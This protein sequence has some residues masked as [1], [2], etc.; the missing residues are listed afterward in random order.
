MWAGRGAV[1]L[2]TSIA[3]GAGCGGRSREPATDGRGGASAGGGGSGGLGREPAHHRPRSPEDCPVERAS[4][5]PSVT[6]C[7]DRP[8]IACE[9]DADC[10]DG[11]AGRCLPSRFPCVTVCSYDECSNDDDCADNK[12]CECRPPG[13]FTANQCVTQSNC[14]ID[15][16]C[17][18]NGFCS[19]SL[20]GEFCAC[21]SVDYCK[22]IGDTS[23]CTP[24]PCACGDSCGHGYFCHTP[25]DTCLD[26]SDCVSGRCSFDLAH[27]SFI[28]AA[29]LPLP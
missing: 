25:A 19:P 5:E 23:M 4:N 8:L 17:G 14:R 27:Q 11:T 2:A 3:L 28:C 16:D 15:A 21:I 24:G 29:C 10:V 7:G 6:N 18:P 22:T 9:R 26:D 20:L 13:A 12:P 1:L